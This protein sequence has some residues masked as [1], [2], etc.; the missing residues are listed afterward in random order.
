[1]APGNHKM[2]CVSALLTLFLLILMHPM[3]EVLS[4]FQ[5]CR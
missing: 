4:L 3:R 2:V 1:M 5:F